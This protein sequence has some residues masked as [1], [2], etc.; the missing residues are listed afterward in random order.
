MSE[1]FKKQKVMMMTMKMLIVYYS[2]SGNTRK[3]A[4]MIHEI[5]KGDMV[6][7]EP[8]VLY[9]KSYRA[10]LEQAKREIKTGYK[11]S[12]KT[13]IENIDD[14]EVIF[15]GSPNWW[16]TIAP[17]VVSFLS[18]YDLSGKIV[19]PFCTHG[20][21]GKQRIIE[22]IKKLCPNSK[23]LAE[24]VAYTDGGSDLK[25]KV[26]KWLNEIGLI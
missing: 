5:V 2:W 9:P 19:V 11:P 23:I 16:G 10:T 15:V 24:F 22:D 25:T 7:L 6:E 4:K 26:S 21:G 20:G 8:E 18:E 14:Y 3:I 12:L 1:V 13:K 17:P